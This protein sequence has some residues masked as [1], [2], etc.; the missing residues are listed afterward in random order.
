[1][2]ERLQ[3]IIAAAG[4]AS[5]RKAEELITQGRV[6][7]NGTVVSELGAKADAA[8][9]HIRVDGKLLQGAEQKTYIML[10]KPKGYVTT[11]SDPEG[12][13]TVM[14][15]V[16]GHRERLYPVGRLDYGSEGLLLMTNDGDLANR[17]TK[18][19]A[20][21]PKT[22]V[23][24]VSGRVEAEAI[25]K[26]RAG[27]YLP[28]ELGKAA[29]AVKT[30]PCEL[31]LLREAENPWYEITLVEGRNRQIRRM[32]EQVGHHV[33]KIKRVRFGPLV[34]N[35]ETGQYRELSRK[36]VGLLKSPTASVMSP[37]RPARPEK[38]FSVKRAER[39][40]AAFQRGKS[41][42]A[43]R[44]AAP[45][46]LLR[47]APTQASANAAPSTR[48]VFDRVAPDA[49]SGGRSLRK[50]NAGPSTRRKDGVSLGMTSGKKFNREGHE[51]T[52][53]DFDRVA[54]DASSGGKR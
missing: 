9:D 7:V 31:R 51:G 36:E 19:S 53:R 12:R 22:Y 20:H 3:K 49:S 15:L 43:R 47:E 4:I 27:V 37:R 42:S 25:A 23:V 34:L 33:E 41:A 24:K 50:E 40:H 30:A 21:V 45:G 10:N 35:V 39:Q 48:P 13:Q 32:F 29:K 38:R 52:R 28:Q 1:M 18:A 2:E 8:R 46:A 11:V 5:R 14:D 6:A 54:P 16:K 26:L 44:G 17:L